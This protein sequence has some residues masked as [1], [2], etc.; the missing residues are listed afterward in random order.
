MKRRMRLKHKKKRSFLEKMIFSVVIAFVLSIFFLFF[1]HFKLAPS[2]TDYATLESKQ[3]AKTIL[4]TA[5]RTTMQEQL[6][7]ASLYTLQ[8]NSKGE[9]ETIDFNTVATNNVLNMITKK[10]TDELLLLENGTI[11]KLNVNNSFKGTHFKQYQSGV[12]CEIP[13]G[14][15]TSHFFFANIGPVIPI[16]FSFVG[17]MDANL[18]SKITP[19]GINNA[20]VELYILVEVTEKITM[21]VSSEEVLITLEVPLISQIMTGK[22]PTYY[23]GSL[24]EHSNVLSLPIK[25][26]EKVE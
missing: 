10:V 16:R 25:E 3:F 11:D 21:P 14:L 2:I 9:I 7:E 8:K 22:I 17:T 6:K 18:K 5:V 26:S 1:L 20:L 19:Y 13:I 23:Q 4:N 12:I 24:S 15:L